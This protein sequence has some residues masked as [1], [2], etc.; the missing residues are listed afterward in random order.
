M[1]YLLLSRYQV[2][3]KRT[4]AKQMWGALQNKNYFALPLIYNPHALNWK[5][6]NKFST[7]RGLFR[8]HW[9][10]RMHTDSLFSFGDYFKC[11]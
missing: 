2:E 8:P 6:E 9:S 3:W 5:Q 7:A 11:K 10:I 4:V 1:D